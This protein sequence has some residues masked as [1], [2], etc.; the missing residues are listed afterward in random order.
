MNKGLQELFDTLAGA[1]SDTIPQILGGVIEL[2]T[3]PFRLII[4]LLA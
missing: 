1:F 3:L 4:A 2:I